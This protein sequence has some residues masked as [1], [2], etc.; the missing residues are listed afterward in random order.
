MR[1]PG[2]PDAFA[3]RRYRRLKLPAGGTVGPTTCP[4]A[5]GAGNPVS[6][7]SHTHRALTWPI[8]QVDAV[9]SLRY[10]PIYRDSSNNRRCVTTCS[11]H[12]PIVFT[13]DAGPAPPSLP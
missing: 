13:I 6:P 2:G 1:P 5:R 10:N 3:P 11:T 7:G 4:E 9:T 8:G 12:Q